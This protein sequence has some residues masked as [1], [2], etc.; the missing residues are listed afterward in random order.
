MSEV[1][2]RFAP[3]PTGY[4]HIGG[5]RTALY[6]YL[7]AKATKG[8]FVLRIEDTDLERSTKEFEALQILDL[9]WLG[10]EYDEGPD[11]PG[12]Y[13]PYRQ[14][15]RLEIYQKYAL[16]L[17]EQGK[18]F[19]CFCSEE[20]LEAMKEKATREG[21]PPHYEGK[22]RNPEFFEEAAARLAA[23]EKPSIRFRAPNKP[24]VLNDHVRGRVVY[25]ENMV[26]DFVIVRSSGLPVYNYCCVVDDVE[27]KI[28]HVI[29]G[30]DHLSN[31]VRQLMI[32]E[33]LSA[34]PPEFAHV[35]LLIGQDR[36]K[37]SKRHGATAVVNYKEE[38]Y[39]P[40]AALNYLCLLG[41]S[42][43]EEKDIFTKEELIPFFNLERFSKSP[44][45]Y[46]IEKFKWVNGQHLKLMNESELRNQT[47]K[48]I[49]KDHL[50]WAQSD[51]WK[52]NAFKLFKDSMLFFN[53]FAR[54]VQENVFQI[55]ESFDDKAK[56]ILAM[57][58]TKDLATH[59]NAELNLIS[60]S[61]KFLS[62]ANFQ[63]IFDKIKT[64]LQLKGKPLF[65]GTRLS[66]TGKDHG[67]ELKDLIPLTPVDVMKK[68]CQKIL[69]FSAQ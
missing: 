65:M 41:W 61:D 49:E 6:N 51:E 27:M 21:R 2:V 29:R 11:K 22:W 43:P 3:S 55:D 33:A 23:G 48:F 39:L 30:E 38:S 4:L 56:E 17:I 52:T 53:D 64:A 68:R 67:P 26:G 5:A 31:T 66:L 58:T 18:A 8:T 14:S 7:F 45:I 28:T 34:T 62:Q 60:S 59:W 24:Y 44:A 57:P 16:Q 20:E 12:K 50:Y 54:V 47:E 10:L 9:K 35:S 15:E 40:G 46:D 25:P 19:Y 36:Q 69:S 32:Y 13:G 42:H 37:L 1:R 63:K